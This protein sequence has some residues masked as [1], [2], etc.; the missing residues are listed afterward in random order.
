M[1]DDPQDSGSEP[2]EPVTA[3]FINF[4]TAD[5]KTRG[6]AAVLVD[7]QIRLARLQREHLH[8]Q[9]IRDRFL[10]AF[11]L[12]LAVA[13]VIVIAITATLLWEAWTSRSVIIDPFDVPNSFASEGRSGKVV[14]SE[15]LDRLRAYQ[16]ATRTSQS[17]RSVRD[18]WSN[19]VLIQIPEAG[20]SIADLQNLLHRWLGRDEHIS[21]S[22]VQEG[23]SIALTIRGDEFAARTF[24]GTANDFEALVTKAA[25]YVYGSSE[26]YLFAVYLSNQGRDTEA[27][28]LSKNAFATAS[29][30]DKPLLLNL[31]GNALDDLGRFREAKEKI[32]AAL[33]ARPRFWMAYDS[34]MGIETSLGD[35]EAVIRTGREMERTAL[36][37]SWLGANVPAV[38]WGNL[39]YHLNDW[40]G[41]GNDIAQDMAQNG[42]HGTEAAEEAP[43]HAESLAHMHEWRHSELE[44]ETSPGSE[45]D[46]FVIAESALV[47][48]IVALDQKE[49]ARAAAALRTG[50]KIASADP[51]VAGNLETSIP[52]WLGLAEGL[53]GNMVGARA[54]F[55]RGGHFVDCLRF[56][57]D[58]DDRQGAWAL[59]QKDYG[60]AVARAPSM[61]TPYESWGEA[62]ARH[63]LPD[64]AIAKFALANEKGPHWADPLK[65]WGDVLLRQGRQALAIKKYAL[66]ARYAANWG[67]LHL[68]WGRALDRLQHHAAALQQ[69]RLAWELDLTATDRASIYGCCG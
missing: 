43:I 55:A 17:K 26:P 29:E 49:F 36:R 3:G 21:G 67:A 35:E 50:D 33:R 14:A 34:L 53:S 28:A 54:D 51:S 59:A 22:I 31:W 7:E 52:C 42:G 64:A 5:S 10:V 32:L 47:R 8:T 46:S 13:G 68:A 24:R 20:I 11:D 66:A 39:D 41:F 61:P 48:G 16:Y 25:E 15:L 65:N 62:L 37:D 57:G 18:A 27:I 12:A 1:N 60:A 23:P 69:Y 9:H 2:I 19:Q 30:S 58:I 56:K 40:Q 38:Y 44:L 6:R 45:K 63:G 4:G